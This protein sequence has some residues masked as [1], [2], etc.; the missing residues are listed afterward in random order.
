MLIPLSR[1]IELYG[2]P[3]TGVLH[4]GAH[5]GEENTAYLA[6]GIPQNAIYWVEAIPAVASSLADRLPNV[7]Q[8]VVS[9]TAEIVEFKVTNNIQSSSILDLKDHLHEHPEIDVVYRFMAT[10]TTLDDIADRHGIRANLLNMDIQGAELK[11]LRGFERHIAGVDVVYTEV[12]AKELYAGCALIGD[13]DAWLG[14]RGFVRV[15][16]QMTHHGWGD[17][18]YIRKPPV[19]HLHCQGRGG[20]QLFQIATSTLLAKELGSD[21]RVSFPID[22]WTFKGVFASDPQNAPPTEPVDTLATYELTPDI[23]SR[24]AESLRVKRNYA[25]SG[26]FESWTNLKNN[27][28][29]I[30]S[31]FAFSAPL[32][33]SNETVVHIRLGD[34]ERYLSAIPEYPY[35][36]AEII[37]DETQPVTIVSD[38]P[39]HPYVRYCLDVLGGAFPGRTISQSPDPTESADFLRMVQCAHLVGTNSTFVFWAGLL[40]A[41]HLH[42]KRTSIFVSDRLFSPERTTALY[43]TD[44]PKWCTVYEM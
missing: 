16:T 39:S 25:F 40:G 11:C 17:A 44:P 5:T 24:I 18:V 33:R 34:I 28:D 35:R 22:P 6:A 7:I 31:M 42:A 26:W 13:L 15:E 2:K 3:L 19:L 10:T 41:L 43:R 12:N 14:Q 23:R 29:A 32:T 30:K 4:V 20:N 21:L 38:S 37:K 27:L 8:A 36:V 9:D 1:V